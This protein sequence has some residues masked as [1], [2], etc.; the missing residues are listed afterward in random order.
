MLSK[1]NRIQKKKDIERIFKKGKSFREDF[2]VLK[3]IKNDLNTCRFGFIVSQKISKKANI[4]NKVKRKLRELVRLKL[5]LL[6]PGLDN[7]LIALCGIEKKDFWEIEK[8]VNNLFK[9][10]KIFRKE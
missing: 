8:M 9:K 4:R 6:K 2:L 3:T 10:A 1:N 7:L 5:K